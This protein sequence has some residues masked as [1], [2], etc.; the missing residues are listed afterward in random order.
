MTRSDPPAMK[1]KIEKD[2]DADKEKEEALFF[3]S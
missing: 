3:F 1:P 2:Q